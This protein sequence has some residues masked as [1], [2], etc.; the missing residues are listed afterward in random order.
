MSERKRQ[1]PQECTDVYGAGSAAIQ[2]LHS[3]LNV[4]QVVAHGQG[5]SVLA[6]PLAQS[7]RFAILYAALK[8]LPDR[9]TPVTY[10][11]PRMTCWLAV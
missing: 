4:F 2:R 11:Q 8:G 1:G 10:R 9:F 6:Q 5:R 7:P 3:G